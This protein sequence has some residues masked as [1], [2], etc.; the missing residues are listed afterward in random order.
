MIALALLGAAT[1]VSSAPEALAVTVYRDPGRGRDRPMDLRFL[2]G[3]ALVTETRTVMLPAGDSEIRFEGVAGG[4]V[5]ASAIVEGLPG[6]VIEKNRD[7]RLLSPAALVDGTLGRRVTLRR[8]DRTSGAVREEEAEIVAGPEGGVV[9]RM[10][11]GIVTLGC[12]GL[13]EKPAYGGVPADLSA[14]PTLSVRVRSPRAGAA[15][16]TLSYLSGAFDWS[17][18]YVATIAPDGRTLDLFAW[19]TLANANAERFP[20]AATQAVAGRLN[21]ER[22]EP[23]RAAAARLSL[24][25]YPLG[26]TTSDLRSPE[27]PPEM[28]DQIVLT[29]RRAFAAPPAIVPAAP[30]PPPPPPPEDLGDLKLYRVPQRVTIASNGQKQVALL[31]KSGIPFERVYRIPASPGQSVA[32][33]P[34]RILLRMRNDEASGL[35]YPLPAGSTSLYGRRG[36]ERLLAGIGTIGDTAK[37]ERFAIAAGTS[38]QVT[39][40]QTTGANRRMTLTVANANPFPAN[41]EVPIGWPGQPDATRAS[42][43]LPRI[44]GIQTWKV[45]LPANGTATLS[46]TYR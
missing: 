42:A 1:I 14:T 6:G 37:G 15:R 29:A 45:A 25:C 24:T 23:L 38:R 44:D 9:L 18:S 26:T 35:G 13:A 12:S 39:L 4:I 32:G 3:F 34:A 20:D 33:R 22:V 7:A 27:P 40:D 17:A 46:F 31:E 10:A 5:P 36:E 16:V 30:P 2:G 11:T 41:V 8:T 21:R 19:L 28:R 43:P